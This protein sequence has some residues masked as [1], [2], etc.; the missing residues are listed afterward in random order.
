MTVF[1]AI[2]LTLLLIGI[3]A[4]TQLGFL[5]FKTEFLPESSYRHYYLS[6]I[7]S[8]FLS[9]L[10]VFYFFWKPRLNF[11]SSLDFTD[12]KAKIVF[13]LIIIAIGFQLAGKPFWD[14]GKIWDYYRYSHFEND[15]DSFNEFSP[16]FYYR[17]FVILIISPIFEEL[18]FRKFLLKKV[19]EKNKKHIAIIVSSLCFA[20]I[21]IETP[22][23]LIPAFIFG[24]LSS[25]IYLKTNR[26]KYS[27]L[28]HFMINALVQ[29]LYVYNSPF[30]KWILNLNFNSLYW[31]LFI[32]GIV[33]TCFGLKKILKIRTGISWEI[34]FMKQQ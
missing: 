3:F 32:I 13:Y 4:I 28:L 19:I 27:I 5:I 7:I 12:Y 21:H 22:N 20:L 23:N 16:R 10:I 34:D 33:L 29:F 11:T 8:I 6:I 15:I 24:I 26:I 18:F 14:I 25:L 1:K 30:D 17:T 9:Y 31:I 2:L